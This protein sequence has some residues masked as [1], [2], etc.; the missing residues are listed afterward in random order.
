MKTRADWVRRCAA[1]MWM[2]T[3]AA[4]LVV[5]VASV[6]AMPDDCHECCDA[7]IGAADHPA[8]QAPGMPRCCLV[9]G[10][11]TPASTPA[12][13]QSTTTL[14]AS[15]PVPAMALL[16]PLSRS[17]LVRPQPSPPPPLAVLQQT[18][19]LLI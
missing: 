8:D 12:T 5:S 2:L 11:P 14:A 13:P 17:R 9:E 19:V 16:Q 18:S 1:A 4:T 6:S 3:F 15:T 10:T 7:M